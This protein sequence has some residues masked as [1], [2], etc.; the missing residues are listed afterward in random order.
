MLRYIIYLYLVFTNLYLMKYLLS[1]SLLVLL[2]CNSIHAQQSY[3]WAK[4]SAGTGDE[5]A[6]S[7]ALGKYGSVYHAGIFTGVADLDPGVGITN[8]TSNGMQDIYFAKY[9]SNGNFVWARSIGST[10]DEWNVEIVTDDTG[11]VYLTGQFMGTIDLDAGAG[12]DAYTAGVADLFIVK[13]D[14]AGNYKWGKDLVGG[15]GNA[16]RQI[17]IDKAGNIYIGGELYN[18]VDF[19]PGPGTAMLS[20]TGGNLFFAK[21]DNSGNYIRAY[22]LGGQLSQSMSVGSFV[23]D[24]SANMY[25]TGSFS[26]SNLCDFDPG[27]GTATLYSAG[28]NKNDV[29]FAK[30]DSAGNYLW[31]KSLADTSVHDEGGY[32]I[33]LG[34][35][36]DIFICGTLGA[37]GFMV[38]TIHAD[39]D[40]GPGIVHLPGGPGGFFA[41]YDSAG[42]YKYAKGLY[43]DTTSFYNLS[44][45]A[46]Q[47]GDVYLS[48]TFRDTTDFDPG[49]GVQELITDS[50]S[51][52]YAG[53]DGTG[54]LKFAYKIGAVPRCYGND[55]ARDTSGNTYIAG[56]YGG[57]VDFDPQTGVANLTA[58]QGQDMVIAKYRDTTIVTA[59]VIQVS[60]KNDIRIYP[61]PAKESI[62]IS[63]AGKVNEV[64]LS[65][66]MGQL[67]QTSTTNTIYLGDL[68]AGVYSIQVSTVNGVF[69]G[70]FVKE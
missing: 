66:M 11:N 55:I 23:L 19:D 10:Q 29:F 33:A 41:R 25:V 51:I 28:L 47:S 34:P 3:V 56:S 16:C 69:T 46:D 30:Y 60:A 21:Y 40:P 15:G 65:N 70:K 4:S 2:C 52:F 22:K 17:A 8:L 37:S 45:V 20:N 39:F 50:S 31:A 59:K 12:V 64:R 18:G 68:A 48:G 6:T 24:M 35:N 63:S 5:Q 44:L 43:S 53:Y 42:N 54:Q 67:L 32:D 36:N 57:M 62:S 26:S 49:A 13:Y 1:L 14:S 61:N 7:I 27:P 38:D 58:V 9:D